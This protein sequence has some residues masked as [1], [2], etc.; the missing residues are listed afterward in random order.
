MVAFLALF[1][2]LAT[3]GVIAGTTLSYAGSLDGRL[4]PGTVVAGEDISGMTQRKALRV[5]KKAMDDELDRRITVAW[6]DRRWHT[7]VRRL[8]GRLNAQAVIA[9]VAA[10]QSGMTWEDWARLRWL[11]DD[12]GVAANV[13]IRHRPRVVRAFV[14]GIAKDVHRDPR[15]A[16][17]EVY[18][19]EIA[20]TASRVGYDARKRLAVR[21]LMSRLKRGSRPVKLAVKTSKPDVTESAFDQVL[22]LDQSDHRLTLFLQRASVDSWVVATGT[23]EYPTP[24]GRYTIT[25]KRYMPTW[26][27]PSPDDWGKNLPEEIPPGPA[28]P[29][30]VRALNWSAPGAI[31]FHG[32]QAV[33]S[34]GRDASHGCV[35]MSNA[36]VSELYDLVDVG[37][38]IVSNP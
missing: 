18:G 19:N 21:A 27:N 13:K 15:D 20:T 28:N 10:R 5:V 12:R 31:R 24:L 32:T 33:D 38:V 16:T 7:S 34:L 8:D 4:L 1:G 35:R 9:D 30:G 2:L 22:L 29:L 36:D 3:G 37:A 6:R 25:E 11:G 17:L 26:I 14:R 23:G